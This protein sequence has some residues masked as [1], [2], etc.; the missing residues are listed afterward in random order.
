MKYRGVE[1]ELI[2]RDEVKLSHNGKPLSDAQGNPLTVDA[3]HKIKGYIDCLI[4]IGW[5]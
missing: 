4:A 3:P 5:V 2:G 1:C